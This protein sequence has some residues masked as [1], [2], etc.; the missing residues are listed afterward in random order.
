M[1]SLDR[2][3]FALDGVLNEFG[4]RFDLQ[5]FHGVVLVR[6]DSAGGYFQH[7]SCFF[8]SATLRQ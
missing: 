6:S 3:D 4:V 2:D 7:A 1:A 8:H 5:K